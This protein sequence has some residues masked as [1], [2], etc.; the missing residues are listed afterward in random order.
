MIAQVISSWHRTWEHKP[1]S[2]IHDNISR[3]HITNKSFT[4]FLEKQK[5]TKGGKGVM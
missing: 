2:I 4:E 3:D 5:I 1:E